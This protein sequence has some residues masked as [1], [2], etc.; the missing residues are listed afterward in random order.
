MTEIDH[1]ELGKNIAKSMIEQGHIKTAVKGILYP[2]LETHKEEII[3]ENTK[4]MRVAATQMGVDFENP[5][6]MQKDFAW[7]RFGRVENESITKKVREWSIRGIFL[8][9][10]VFLGFDKF[11]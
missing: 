6:E 8:A 3:E 7:M 4:A 10:M 2:I 5:I 11:T 9:I 1:K